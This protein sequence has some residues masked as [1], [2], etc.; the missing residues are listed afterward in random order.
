MLEAAKKDEVPSFSNTSG[1]CTK[2]LADLQKLC[3]CALVHS[4]PALS[5]DT[6]AGIKTVVSQTSGGARC[7]LLIRAN[8]TLKT[9]SGKNG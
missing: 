9:G 7:A 6:I 3:A 8:S 4:C 2:V 5:Q 1:L